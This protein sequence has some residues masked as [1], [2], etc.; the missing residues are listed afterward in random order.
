LSR[1]TSVAEALLEW[2]RGYDDSIRLNAYVEE[3]GDLSLVTGVGAAQERFIDGTE[4]RRV[5]C[6]LCLVAPW[7]EGPDPVNADALATGEGWLAWV[8]GEADAGRLPEMPEGVTCWAVEVDYTLPVMA[9]VY[10]DGATALYR[11]RVNIDYRA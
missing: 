9:E 4:L 5:P 10:P 2:A 3:V 11:F 7:S 8:E 6:D 1:A